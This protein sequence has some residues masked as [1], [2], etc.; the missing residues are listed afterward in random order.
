MKIISG[1]IAICNVMF[2]VIRSNTEIAITLP[3]IRGVVRRGPKG[4]MPPPQSSIEWIFFT[5]KLAL[6]GR[7][8]CGFNTS[9]Y[10]GIYGES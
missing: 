3:R 6:L 9:Y 7:R 1:A 5:E 8:A 2:K 10:F 4:G